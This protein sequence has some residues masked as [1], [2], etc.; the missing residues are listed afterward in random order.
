MAGGSTENG[1]PKNYTQMIIIV[2]GLV[3]LAMSLIV[4]FAKRKT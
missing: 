3:A 4:Y 2:F 1:T